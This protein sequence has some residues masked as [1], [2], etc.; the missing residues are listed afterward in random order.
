MCN[1]VA[2]NKRKVS[3]TEQSSSG[4][5]CDLFFPPLVCKK[6]AQTR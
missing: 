2:V 1:I 4:G 6:D 3:D 5:K